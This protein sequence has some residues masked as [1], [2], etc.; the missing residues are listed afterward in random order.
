MHSKYFSEFIYMHANLI[1]TS[2]RQEFHSRIHPINVI[3]FTNMI[4]SDSERQQHIHFTS[5]CWFAVTGYSRINLNKPKNEKW[6]K[7][8]EKGNESKAYSDFG[9]WFDIDKMCISLP[10]QI[11]APTTAIQPNE[12]SFLLL[13]HLSFLLVA[14]TSC[15]LATSLT[16]TATTIWSLS[17]E[18]PTVN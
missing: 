2:L 6:G 15:S 12:L 14:R 9:F 8:R 17:Y 18:T 3:Y 16:F 10:P 5:W 1:F 11:P 13:S 4:F 7:K